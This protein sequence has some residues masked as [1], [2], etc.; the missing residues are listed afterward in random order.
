MIPPE[1][2]RE[3]ARA[4]DADLHRARHLIEGFFARPR[5]YR[6]LAIRHDERAIHLLGATHLAAAVIWL[7]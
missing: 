4:Y 5:R 2:D 1:A 6:A 7:D 3:E